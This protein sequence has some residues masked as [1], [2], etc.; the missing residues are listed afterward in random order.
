MAAKWKTGWL[1]AGALALFSAVGF[2]T[3]RSYFEPIGSSSMRGTLFGVVGVAIL[4]LLLRACAAH[5]QKRNVRREPPPPLPV[6]AKLT[7]NKE[8]LRLRRIMEAAEAGIAFVSAD[9]LIV[10][11]NEAL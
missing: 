1:F 6:D 8:E 2:I 3:V 9:G 10:E 5:V 4:L 7:T 11:A